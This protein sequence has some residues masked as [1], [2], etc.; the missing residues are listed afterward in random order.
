MPASPPCGT[1]W[2]STSGGGDLVWIQGLYPAGKWPDIKIFNAVLANFLERY[3][4]IEANDG[5]CGH[6]Y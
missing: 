1:S 4:H 5:Y 2:A 3:E 6:P